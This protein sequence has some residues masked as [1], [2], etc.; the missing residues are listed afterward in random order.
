MC[1]YKITPPPNVFFA[2]T[3]PN[4]EI[5]GFSAATCFYNKYNLYK[6][7]QIDK[8]FDY[9][10]NELK[11]LEFIK[12]IGKKPDIPLVSFNIDNIH[13]HD[14]AQ[15]LDSKNICVRTGHHC[16]KPLHSALNLTATVRASL[17]HYNTLDE[18]KKFIIAIKKI[19][20]FFKL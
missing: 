8:T 2:G 12:L 15:F 19:K 20:E 4:A 10:Y 5:A 3:L 13:P 17:L 6:D 9:L 7:V 18:V 11:N 16:A 14:V 1:D